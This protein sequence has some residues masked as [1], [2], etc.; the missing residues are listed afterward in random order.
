MHNLRYLGVELQAKNRRYAGRTF[1]DI[2]NELLR[3][4]AKVRVY[5]SLAIQ[6]AKRQLADTITYA[7]GRDD[8]LL[9]VHALLLITEIPRVPHAELDMVKN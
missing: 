5:D 4:G 7:K 6:E 1:G 3:R 9:D 2:I 8:A